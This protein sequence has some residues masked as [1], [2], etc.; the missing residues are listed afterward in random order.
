MTSRKHEIFNGEMLF[1]CAQHD[2]KEVWI[3]GQKA[4]Y[5]ILYLGCMC[6]A[7]MVSVDANNRKYLNF[8]AQEH[9]PEALNSEK[10]FKKNNNRYTRSEKV[11]N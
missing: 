8:N 11:R 1:Y 5:A 3:E 10:S 6:T 7:M 2:A 4:T 9:I